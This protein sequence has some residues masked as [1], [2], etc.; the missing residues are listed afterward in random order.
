MAQRKVKVNNLLEVDIFGLITVTAPP[1]GVRVLP[2]FANLSN[3]LVEFG[4]GFD[5]TA[6]ILP[7]GVLI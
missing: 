2:V 3:G 4:R 5:R 6:K 1:P 7:S